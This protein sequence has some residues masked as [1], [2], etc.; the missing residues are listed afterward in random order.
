[1]DGVV[2]VVPLLVGC[3]QNFFV[4]VLMM[5]VRFINDEEK[6]WAPDKIVFMQTNPAPHR[7]S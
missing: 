4:L 1:M 5:L 7:T 3:D 6:I 2:G